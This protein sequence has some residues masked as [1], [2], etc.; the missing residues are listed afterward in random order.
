MPVFWIWPFTLIPSACFSLVH[1]VGQAMQG[2][3]PMRVGTI[4]CLLSETCCKWY[5]GWWL[6]V[7][8]HLLLAGFL[9]GWFPTL[10]ME[11]I[12]SSKNAYSHMDHM[13]LYPRWWKHSYVLLSDNYSFHILC[14]L[15]TRIAVKHWNVMRWVVL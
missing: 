14:D 3:E 5:R 6:I 10:K 2:S 15:F 7:P 11:V 13:V 9:L 1:T 4:P 8:S 12:H